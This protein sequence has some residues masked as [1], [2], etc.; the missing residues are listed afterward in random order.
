MCRKPSPQNKTTTDVKFII[1]DEH[2]VAYCNIPKIASSTWK[3]ILMTSTTKGRQL[4]VPRAS[5]RASDSKQ[6]G[7]RS[8]SISQLNRN[9]KTRKYTRFMITRHPVERFISAFYEKINS[10][11]PNATSSYMKH[12]IM[13]QQSMRRSVRKFNK[14]DEFR[15][16]S[17]NSFARFVLYSTGYAEKENIHWKRYAKRCDPCNIE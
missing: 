6:R 13:Q 2:K 3:R 14:I 16:V 5:H 7:L 10:T 17:F 12:V 8:L 11:L 1:D 15:N 9:P 4:P